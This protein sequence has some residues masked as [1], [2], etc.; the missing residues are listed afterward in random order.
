MSPCGSLS[1]APWSWPHLQPWLWWWLPVVRSS[2]GGLLQT[3][4]WIKQSPE[5]EG[6]FIAGWP[7][8]LEQ[9]LGP[10]EF[11][12]LLI[13][14][15]QNG[16]GWSV[17]FLRPSGWVVLKQPG[18][19]LEN[20]IQLNP[21]LPPPPSHLLHPQSLTHANPSPQGQESCG[22]RETFRPDSPTWLFPP[23]ASS[24]A[25]LFRAGWPPRQRGLWPQPS[26]QRLDGEPFSEQGCPDLG[27]S[28]ELG[29]TANSPPPRRCFRAWRWLKGASLLGAPGAQPGA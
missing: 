10:G 12:W 19:G 29:C 17:G 20:Q 5:P 22:D 11:Q 26:D 18:L 2:C 23:A 27:L 14:D 9:G 28:W 24:K 1:L 25:E 8:G 16:D 3:W 6:L 7:R 13:R 21:S 4:L 15:Q